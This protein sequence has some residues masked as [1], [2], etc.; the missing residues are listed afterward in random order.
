MM[1]KISFLE[2][3]G[4]AFAVVFPAIGCLLC[5]LLVVFL[6]YKIIVWFGLARILLGMALLLIVIGTPIFII[7]GFNKSFEGG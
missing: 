3:I 1:R 7:Y 5:L 6:A 2:K 4:D